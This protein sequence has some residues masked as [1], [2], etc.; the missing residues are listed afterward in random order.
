VYHRFGIP[1][2]RRA[3]LE[4]R[5]SGGMTPKA[6]QGEGRRGVSIEVV[7]HEPHLDARP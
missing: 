4:R 2:N 6:G 3:A 1:V 5:I 7:M